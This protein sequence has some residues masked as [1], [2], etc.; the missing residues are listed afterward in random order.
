[1]DPFRIGDL[2]SK[3]TDWIQQTAQIAFEASQSISKIWLPTVEAAIEEVHESL[4]RDGISRVLVDGNRVVAWIGA[5][6]QFSGRV[7]EIHPL[8]VAR[9][10]QGNGLSRQMVRH[11]EVWARKQ[12]ALTLLVGTSDETKATSLSGVDVYGDVGQAI[13]N[14]HQLAPYPCGFWLRLGFRIVGVLPDAEGFGKPNIM[15][16]KPL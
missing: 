11:V 8:I 12:G 10:N 16:A 4:E 5:F 7:V 9:A 3:N 1:M 15:M 2:G 6:R 13:A 14:F